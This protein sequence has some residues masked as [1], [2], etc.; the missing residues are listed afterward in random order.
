[1]IVGRGASLSSR[2]PIASRR[3]FAAAAAA[4]QERPFP[5]AKKITPPNPKQLPS[6]SSS[7]SF[8]NNKE[9]KGFDRTK[10]ASTLFGYKLDETLLQDRSSPRSLPIRHS[11]HQFPGPVCPPALLQSTSEE[12]IQ[13]DIGSLYAGAVVQGGRQREAHIFAVQD[14]FEYLLRG[15]SACVQGSYMNVNC[16]TEP[17]Q[18]VEPK[19]WTIL[20]EAATSPLFVKLHTTSS[21]NYSHNN[22]TTQQLYKYILNMSQ[23][24][25]RLEQEAD[26][27]WKDKH[28]VLMTATSDDQ[29]QQEESDSDDDEDEEEGDYDED[30]EDE[31]AEDEDELSSEDED[32]DEDD[33]DDDEEEKASKNTRSQEDIDHDVETEPSLASSAELQSVGLGAPPGPT[34]TMYDL[35]LDAYALYAS[36]LPAK[37]VKSI[38]HVIDHTRTLLQ[39]VLQR[40]EADGGPANVNRSTIPTSMT[41]NALIRT[42][43]N[44]PYDGKSDLVRDEAI[45]LAF[46]TFDRLF[47]NDAV[48]RNSATYTHLLRVV[49]KFIPNSRS[50]GNIAYGLFV[51]ACD[52][53]VV[54][55]HVWDTLKSFGVGT[56]CGPEFD[57][58]LEQNMGNSWKELPHRW[59]MN[60]SKRRYTHCNGAY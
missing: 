30:A 41:F 37:D 27:Y 8:W 45:D 20:Q 52:E 56:G 11:A 43:A 12:I 59:R 13:S 46:T 6:P 42:A 40:H 55:E 36:T 1:M 34:T 15:Y 39:T 7:S 19:Y 18:H 32:E 3:C 38:T 31:D 25:A 49:Y 23:L 10:K 14:K 50:K 33:D 21:N 2:C 29:Q 35:L 48:D 5:T 9:V 22:N 26:M 58:Y 16:G 44:V 60:C 54:D 57:R 17:Q 53:S 47:R 51:K 4:K 24:I 28:S